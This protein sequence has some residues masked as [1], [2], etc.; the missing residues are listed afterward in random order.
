MALQSV[1][2]EHAVCC[3]NA[4]HVSAGTCVNKT[5]EALHPHRAGVLTVQFLKL[6][7]RE[8]LESI[9]CSQ[10]QPA[11]NNFIFKQI[12][13]HGESNLSCVLTCLG[14]CVCRLETLPQLTFDVV[15]EVILIPRAFTSGS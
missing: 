9:S 2:A 10:R 12:G 8:V 3:R 6:C 11:G 14:V 15:L 13:K 4:A 5:G 7:A 1:A